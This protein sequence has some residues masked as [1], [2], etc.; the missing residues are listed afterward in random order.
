MVVAC[1]KLLVIPSCGLF[2]CCPNSVATL[3]ASS[4][5][6][7]LN[8]TLCVMFDSSELAF[9]ECCCCCLMEASEVGFDN[10]AV[11]KLIEQ[12]FKEPFDNVKEFFFNKLVLFE[13]VLKDVLMPDKVLGAAGVGGGGGAFTGLGSDDDEK[14]LDGLEKEENDLLP[15]SAPFIKHGE[16]ESVVVA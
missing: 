14:V 5:F 12:A 13:Q 11:G 2:N 16:V 7:T 1:S 6:E 3:W 8:A 9:V 15:S 4:S 10:S